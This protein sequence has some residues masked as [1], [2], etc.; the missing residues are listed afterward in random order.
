MEPLGEFTESFFGT[1]HNYDKN[2][3]GIDYIWI[4]QKGKFSKEVAI[5][6]GKPVSHYDV[7]GR[8]DYVHHWRGRYDDEQKAVYIVPPEKLFEQY[9]TVE[10]RF[11]IPVP[12]KLTNTLRVEFGNVEFRGDHCEL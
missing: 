5:Q 12:E 9:F 3:K 7:W 1:G 6:D 11:L 2:Y 8:F 10:K 4:W